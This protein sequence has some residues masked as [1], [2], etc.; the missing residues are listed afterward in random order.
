MMP[1]G[2]ATGALPQLDEQLQ[3]RANAQAQPDKDQQQPQLV[4]NDH[5]AVAT[6]HHLLRG[7]IADPKHSQV[8]SVCKVE[9]EQSG[10]Q[11]RHR[12]H[13]QHRRRAA[14]QQL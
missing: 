2:P 9:R 14:H 3:D 11:H 8:G 1:L 6:K 13:T 4:T 10:I 12:K 5:R 7:G